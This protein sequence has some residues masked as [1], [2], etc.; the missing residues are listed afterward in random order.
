M[1]SFAPSPSTLNRRSLGSQIAHHLREEIVLGRL[2]AGTPVSQQWLCE[3]Y[4]TSRMPVRDALVKLTA[5][6]LIVTTRGGHSVVAQLTPDDILDVFEIEAIVHGRAARRAAA[7]VRGEDVAELRELHDSMV[8][9]E[10]SGDLERLTELNWA[11]HKRINALS[12]SAK[13]IAMLRTLSLN[14]PQTYL[15]EL[16]DWAAQTNRD[17]AGIVAALADADGDA[18]ER[19]VAGHV[20]RAGGN[21]AAYLARKGVA[22]PDPDALAAERAATRS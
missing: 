6:G 18:A 11:F 4:G 17:H 2:A 15:L 8:Q 1:P 22:G 21:L 10:H 12:G 13:L 19:L 16:P 14:I 5:E 3:R 20:R 7:R 9:A